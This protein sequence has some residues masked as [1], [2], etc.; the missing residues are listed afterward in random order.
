[1]SGPV[2]GVEA[3]QEVLLRLPAPGVLDGEEAGD[4][5]EDALRTQLVL[6]D[7][8]SAPPQSRR[9]RRSARGPPL[10]SAAGRGR[11]WPGRRPSA[12]RRPS[13][14]GEAGAWA[15]A[16]RA[17]ARGDETSYAN[18]MV[19][20][21][22]FLVLPGRLEDERAPCGERGPVE[23]V[24]GGEVTRASVTRPTSSIESSS[25]GPCPRRDPERASGG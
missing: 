10:A 8:G 7:N 18:W 17:A 24:P 5:L 9:T 3:A 23:A 25:S 20:R 14:P 21:I 4:R 19:E 12:R 11:A 13:A 6:S 15:A 1:M 2:I 16:G 22:G